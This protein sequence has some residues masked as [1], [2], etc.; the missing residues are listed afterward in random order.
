M[1]SNQ[2]S[3]FII[4]TSKNGRTGDMVQP[5]R[6]GA[7]EGGASAAVRTVQEVRWD[8]MLAADGI[9]VG[10]PVR[11]GGVD[12][13]IKRLLDVTAY[14]DYPGPLS[15]KVGGAFTGGGRPGG[16]AELALLSM[17]HILLNH[18]MVIQGNAH[19]SHYGPVSLRESS[20]EEVESTCIHWGRHW[21][22]LVRRLNGDVVSRL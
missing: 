15:G 22:Q 18:G 5:V 17:L 4:Y 1:A 13:Q 11:F 14:Q 20:R 10:T 3:L 8:E 12:W 16:G 6:Q 21:A 19:S 2:H 9:I 7:I